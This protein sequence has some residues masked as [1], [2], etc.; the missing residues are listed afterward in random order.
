MLDTHEAQSRPTTPLEQQ[1]AK[2]AGACAAP[3]GSSAGLPGC[4]S[5]LLHMAA[6]Q[7][8]VELAMQA[9]KAEGRPAY[10]VKEI[11]HVR[12]DLVFLQQEA[13]A[14]PAITQC[15]PRPLFPMD[16][17]QVIHACSGHWFV[18]FK[19]DNGHGPFATRQAAERYAKSATR[20]ERGEV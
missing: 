20:S 10:L 16:P 7:H 19:G 17:V 5:A 4:A 1:A 13:A 6:A 14:A 8:S 2:P 3:A 9:A 15:G 12:E 18:S 11:D